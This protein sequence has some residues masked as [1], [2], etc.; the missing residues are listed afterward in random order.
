MCEN[1]PQKSLDL[2]QGTPLRIQKETGAVRP[3]VHFPHTCCL[4]QYPRCTNP[5]NQEGITVD[6]SSAK[7][8]TCGE[9][10]FCG[11]S[12]AS[13]VTNHMIACY[14]ALMQIYAISHQLHPD[15]AD[16]AKRRLEPESRCTRHFRQYYLVPHQSLR[17]SGRVFR[18]ANFV[19]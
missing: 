10:P 2:S 14:E 19:L 4:L 17:V 13:L 1:Y 12:P 11:V 16:Q 7:S 5:S 15:R 9:S 8:N 18:F 6:Y 3:C